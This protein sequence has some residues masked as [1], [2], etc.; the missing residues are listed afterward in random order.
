MNC[1]KIEQQLLL[2]DAGE[3]S[4]RAVT[5]LETHID[6]C[7]RCRAYRDNLARLLPAAH[8]ALAAAGPSATAL[9]AVSE[10][11]R[12]QLVRPGIVVFPL[13]AW[14]P[15]ALAYAAM[16]VL[17]LGGWFMVT[18][19][20]GTKRVREAQAVVAAVIDYEHGDDDGQ[21]REEE[22]EA[23]ARELLRMEGFLPDETQDLLYSEQ[24]PDPTA[25]LSR[26][27]HAPA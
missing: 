2:A 5:R 21:T 23:L 7:S 4:A 24:V 25:L 26:S 17:L 11:A 22:L 15:R 16:L 27:T 12:E 3:L 8:D 1:D 10:A 14:Q 9:A 6:T 18:P 19:M 13:P 20:R